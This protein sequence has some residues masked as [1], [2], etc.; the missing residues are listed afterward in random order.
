MKQALVTSSRDGAPVS[1]STAIERL[2]NMPSVFLNWLR[3]RKRG[4]V[5]A[6]WPT[7]DDLLRLFLMVIILKPAAVMLPRR[8]SLR[9]AGCC[10]AIISYVPTSGRGALSTMRK[11]FGMEV[12]NAKRAARE[13]LLQPFYAFVV[14][15]RILLE[16]ENLDGWMIE[17]RNDQ[18]VAQ[19][20][21][22]GR[23]YIVATG[24]FTRES[25]FVLYS[26]RVSAGNSAAIH[27]PLPQ[28]RAQIH[29]GLTRIQYG[30]LL[31]TVRKIRPDHTFIWVG[32]AVRKVLRT[33]AHPKCQMVIGADAFWDQGGSS[34]HTRP[35][36]GMKVRTFS[37]GAA[38]LSRLAQCP[39]VP[40]ASYVDADG[41][42]VL[43]W[44]PVI[45][46]P[47]R[48]DEGA[49]IRTT[50]VVLD[51]LEN[52]IGRRPTQYVLHIGEERKFDPV[53][54]TWKDFDEKTQ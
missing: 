39:V 21:E 40:C 46:P 45:E 19:F 44:G 1:N 8:T 37:T 26:S 31:R 6:F 43:E 2:L 7:V 49:D 34:A 18:G 48:Q 27:L 42:I 20:R 28:K 41:T 36:A 52:A 22:S 51:F 12:A 32:D 15:Q 11:A 13:Y 54:G 24:H 25:Q 10:G 16:R 14:S 23:S 38:T 17:E 53:L 35:F 33:L 30:Q 50:N 29:S 5:A 9:V 4:F 47:L 3:R